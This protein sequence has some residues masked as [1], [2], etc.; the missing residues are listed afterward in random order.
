MRTTFRFS[1]PYTRDGKRERERMRELRIAE[2]CNLIAKFSS[3]ERHWQMTRRPDYRCDFNA[4]LI[5]RRRASIPDGLTQARNAPSSSLFIL[6]LFFPS[7][8]FSFLFL[9]L[10]ISVLLFF[11]CSPF[12]FF[13][14]FFF[15]FCFLLCLSSIPFYLSFFSPLFLPLLLK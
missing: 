7:F 9:S 11:L 6:H 1:L 3:K 2:E 8:S 13:F 4:S 12:F 5:R 10:F 14:H 15:S